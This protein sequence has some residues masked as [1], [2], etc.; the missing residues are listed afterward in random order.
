M[1]KT[2]AKHNQA[3]QLIGGTGIILSTQVLNE[4]C[5]NLLRKAKYTEIEIQKTIDNF[6]VRYSIV[7]VT[8]NIIRQSSTL[9]I[10]YRLSY[11]DSIIIATAID[12]NCDVVYSEDMQN[13]QHIG[14][15]VIQNPFAL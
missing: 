7:N 3:L 14:G 1:D 12:A 5:S 10:S 9:R 15:L 2:S 13:G 6:Q 11:W 4:V 8:S